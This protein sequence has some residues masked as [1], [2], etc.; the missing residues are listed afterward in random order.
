MQSRQSIRIRV[1][2]DQQLFQWSQDLASP[3]NSNRNYSSG[4]L[5]RNQGNVYGVRPDDGWQGTAR[6]HFSGT[7]LKAENLSI[8]DD[9]R[10]SDTISRADS[11]PRSLQTAARTSSTPRTD[12]TY[13]TKGGSSARLG[14]YDNYLVD[15][16]NCVIVGKQA[17]AAQEHDSRKISDIHGL[18]HYLPKPYFNDMWVEK[19][20][21]AH[22]LDHELYC[23][24]DGLTRRPRL[25]LAA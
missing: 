20:R 1:A 23:H 5:T 2:K 25:D 21:M 10:P 16:R 9:V 11:A 14:Y 3:F 18:K 17:T 12:A 13:A 22:I 15:N 7:I 6:D 4:L 24:C 19:Y 8:P